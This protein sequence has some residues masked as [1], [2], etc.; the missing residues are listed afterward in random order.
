METTM[1]EFSETARPE[2]PSPTADADAPLPPAAP[3]LYDPTRNKKWG[4]ATIEETQTEFDGN[5]EALAARIRDDKDRRH[6]KTWED[7][8]ERASEALL[9]AQEAMCRR[10]EE[11]EFVPHPGDNET[12]RS[13]IKM[14]A[15][16]VARVHAILTNSMPVYRTLLKSV[17]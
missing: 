14:G 4:V 2:Q 10:T 13:R 16:A 17:D 8:V 7:A 5:Q 12:L 11:G 1:T 6:K 9:T 15:E 3:K